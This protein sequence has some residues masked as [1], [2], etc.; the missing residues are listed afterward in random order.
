[1]TET[2]PQLTIAPPRADRPPLRANVFREMQHGNTQLMPLFPYLHPG[3]MVPCG[4]ILRGGPGMRYGHF[5]HHNTED[6]VAVALATNNAMLATGQV[7][8]GPRVHGV[9]SFLKNEADP[10]AFGIILITQRQ[11][12]T[13]RQIEA[14]SLR[15]DNCREEIFHHEFDAT[16]SENS[17][18]GRE[19]FITI[20]IG[21]DILR[22]F[23][24]DPALRTCAQC[25]HVNQPFPVAA[26]GWD[27]YAEQSATALAGRAALDALARGG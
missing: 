21:P 1:M 11:P 6:E 13:G 8:I 19:P 4:A 9:N 10:M 3:A 16:P 27:R 23:N 20:A 7:F 14:Y 5:F 2:D 18:E 15:C 17:D 25:G 22:D 26:W 12:E 24:A